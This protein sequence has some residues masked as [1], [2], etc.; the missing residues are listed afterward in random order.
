MCALGVAVLVLLWRLIRRDS[1]QPAVSGFFGVAVCALVAYVVGE[2]KGYFL[3]GIWMSLVW[4][5][6]LV[7]ESWPLAL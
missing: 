6:V 1:V 5:V 3:V 2:S 7:A 4:A